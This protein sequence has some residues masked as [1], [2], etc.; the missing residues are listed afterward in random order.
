M[1][2]MS[3]SQTLSPPPAFSRIRPNRASDDVVAQIRSAILGRRFQPGDRLPTE[4]A[5]AADLGVSRTTLRE[6]LNTLETL[7]ALARHP[8]RG[9]VLQPIDL[10]LLAEV[11]QFLMVRSAA[12]INDLFV[13]RR[14]LEISLLPL[15]AEHAGEEQFQRMEMANRLMEAEIEADGIAVDGDVAFHRALLAAANNKFLSQFGDLIQEFFRDRRT[16]MLVH[17]G[18][19]RNAVEEHRQM[20]GHLRAGAVGAAQ[21]VMERHLDRYRERG[22]VHTPGTDHPAA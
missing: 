10:S 17:A 2:Q 4:R 5:L 19:A 21:A 7:G 9:C 16:R 20:V 15:V 22:V 11:S 14:V 6:A 18:V 8:G 12:D 13:A 1:G 3:D